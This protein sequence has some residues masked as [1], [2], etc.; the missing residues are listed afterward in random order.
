MNSLPETEYTNVNFEIDTNETRT[1]YTV[2]M[3]H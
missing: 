1:R 3:G 2:R